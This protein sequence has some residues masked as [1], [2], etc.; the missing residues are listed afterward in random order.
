MDITDKHNVA[1]E[2]NQTLLN[3]KMNQVKSMT[4]RKTITALLDHAHK[5][6]HE[7]SLKSE[8][9]EELKLT[10]RLGEHDPEKMMKELREIEDRESSRQ[11]TAEAHYLLA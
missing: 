9:K 2:R 3:R 10:Q 1:K 7:S 6:D 4:R 11:K 5:I 8:S